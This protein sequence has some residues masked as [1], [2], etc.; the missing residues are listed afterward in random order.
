MLFVSSFSVKRLYLLN[1]LISLNHIIVLNINLWCISRQLQV[2]RNLWNKH[3]KKKKT[4]FISSTG[5]TGLAW[6]GLKTNG[7]GSYFFYNSNS[8]TLFDPFDSANSDFVL[9]APDEPG[10]SVNECGLLNTTSWEWIMDDCNADIAYP[11]CERNDGRKHL[12]KY[13]KPYIYRIRKKNNDFSFS[14]DAL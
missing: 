11:L 9:W 6:I 14:L 8:S 4:F 2:Y 3:W 12:L 10:P 13:Y 1:E 5:C 7:T